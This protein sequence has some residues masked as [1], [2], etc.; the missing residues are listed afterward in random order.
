LVFRHVKS[1]RTT[2][3]NVYVVLLSKKQCYIKTGTGIIHNLLACL[4]LSINQKGQDDTKFFV[5]LKFPEKQKHTYCR[6][7]KSSCMSMP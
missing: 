2:G 1:G 3:D 7:Y 4:N 6:V 5:F